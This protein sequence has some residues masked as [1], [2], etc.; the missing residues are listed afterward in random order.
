MH[1]RRRG[2]QRVTLGALI[3]DVKPRAALSDGR[4]NYLAASRAVA[5]AERETRTPEE[6]AA[7]M[8]LSC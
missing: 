8:T 7:L 3:R 6:R 4:V 2:D 5:Q 1:E